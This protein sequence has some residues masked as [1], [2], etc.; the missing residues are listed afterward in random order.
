[1]SGKIINLSSADPKF[2]P[3]YIEQA[4]KYVPDH[5]KRSIYFFYG[6]NIPEK[7]RIPGVQVHSV[8]NNMD[9]L[10]ELKDFFEPGD[11]LVS[12]S[13]STMQLKLLKNLPEG[14]KKVWI[15]WGWELYNAIPRSHYVE[16]WSHYHSQKDPFYKFFL[17]RIYNK[18]WVDPSPKVKEIV[19]QFD[20]MATYIDTDYELAKN[21]NNKLKHID[22]RYVPNKFQHFSL[23]AFN[24]SPL[25]LKKPE[26]IKLLLGNS[27]APTNNHFEALRYLKRIKFP[28]IIYCPLSYGSQEKYV[29]NLIE[30]GTS[31][32]GN[33]FNPITKFM[34]RN[35][36]MGFLAGIDVFWFNNIRQ[37]SMGNILIAFLMGK[38][39]IFNPKSFM[40]PFFRKLGLTFFTSFQF[41]EIEKKFD[42][43]T[44]QQNREIVKNLWDVKNNTAFFELIG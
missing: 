20:Y 21:F 16:F 25:Q 4:R 27:T 36:Y 34:S 23:P 15:L 28:G 31:M 24:F 33:R 19:S 42:I 39:V 38:P 2:L 1:M 14:V 43:N 44:A 22:F 12:H 17:K 7:L 18:Y 26:K 10:A 37:M 5:D 9:S 30:T 32:Y 35:D 3:D 11:V 29:K 13:F 41:S 8:P 6:N 40:I